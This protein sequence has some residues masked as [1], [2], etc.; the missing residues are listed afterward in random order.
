MQWRRGYEYSGGGGYEYS[1]GGG[2]NTVEEG[3]MNTVE[4]I[5]KQY[6]TSFRCTNGGTVMARGGGGGTGIGL[7][8]F[9]LTCEINLHY[10][11]HAFSDCVD[12]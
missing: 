10:T 7:D 6:E 1:G 5:E 2:M 8:G 4:N 3:S 11:P 12:I 9:V